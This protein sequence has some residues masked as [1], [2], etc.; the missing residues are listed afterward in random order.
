MITPD[1]LVFTGKYAQLCQDFIMYKRSLGYQYDIRQCYSVK[2]LCDYLAEYGGDVTG[3]SRDIV[4]G[5]LK[6]RKTESS[7]T[8]VK[9]SYIIRQFGMY[10]SS[11]GY[12]SYL[13]SYDCIKWDKSFVPYIYSKDEIAAII[14]ASES[15]LKV[16]Q[17]PNSYL[18][19]PMLIRILF[20]CG[21][22]VSE[23]L[24]L[25]EN[26]ICRFALCHH[27]IFADYNHLFYNKFITF[28]HLLHFI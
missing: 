19:Y 20:G 4:E 9:R 1:E 3:L 23:A 12:Q 25:K 21:L 13:P 8:Q 28:Y 10:L 6:R 18:V 27:H 14:K 26:D 2:Y 15:L 7:S 11:L 24:C 5:F 17:A 16:H 22:R